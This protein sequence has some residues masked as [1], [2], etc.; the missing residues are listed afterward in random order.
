MSKTTSCA[1]CG[2]VVAYGAKACPQ[3]G[4]KGPSKP[5]YKRPILSALVIAAGIGIISSTLD[6][7][8][9]KAKRAQL[10]ALKTPEQRKAEQLQRAQNAKIDTGAMLATTLSKAVAANMKNPKSFDLIEAHTNAE[11][12]VACIGY[13]GTNSFNA[14]VPGN[15]FTDGKSAMSNSD[16]G[17]VAGWNKNCTAKMLDVTTQAKLNL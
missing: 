12:T 5:F 1:A 7:E 11:G 2:G 3:C 15:A 9:D 8:N 17:F 16:K 6:S 10:E 13:R 4:A 14:V